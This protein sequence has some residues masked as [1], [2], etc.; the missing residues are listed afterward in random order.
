MLGHLTGRLDHIIGHRLRPDQ[1]LQMPGGD[2]F[3]IGHHKRIVLRPL[4]AKRV[5][6]PAQRAVTDINRVR[7]RLHA[8]NRNIQ[9]LF[10]LSHFMTKDIHY[11][12]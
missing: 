12:S 5:P 9:F 3:G 2:Q 4:P 7:R 11:R 10:V 6:N 1:R 8:G